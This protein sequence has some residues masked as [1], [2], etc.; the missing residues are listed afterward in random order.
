MTEVSTTGQG[1]ILIVDDEPS[2]LF[3]ME[4]FL[5]RLGY[6]VETFLAA[7]PALERFQSDPAAYALVIADISL[8]EISGSEMIARLLERNP[9]LCVLV[10]TGLPFTLT[11]IPEPLRR[12]VEYLQK[13]FAPHM[14]AAAVRRLLE[15]SGHP[16]AASEA[17]AG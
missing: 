16:P 7:A 14:L 8:P 1:R 2:L 11:A 3:L 5:S 15:A 13:P 4:Q 6:A 10:C 12:R 9:R 17:S